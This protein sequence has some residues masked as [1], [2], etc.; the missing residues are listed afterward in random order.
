MKKYFLAFVIIALAVITWF[1]WNYIHHK[2]ANVTKAVP[3]TQKN[4][5]RTI[6]PASFDKTEYSIDKA[7]S[8]WVVVNKKRPLSA[9][10]IPAGLV[11]HPLGG[12]VRPEASN[13]LDNLLSAAKT[14]GVTFKMISA[15]RSYG[16]QASVYNGYV[17]T[18]GQANADT[19]SARPGHS[20]HQTGLAADLGAQNGSCDLEACFGDTPAGQWLAAHAHEHGFI[21]RY[22]EGKESVTGY[23]Y[24]PWHIRFVGVEL[25]TELVKTG[26]TMEE[27]FG[28]PAAPSY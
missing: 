9:D 21:I 8:I 5:D 2:S 27:F 6:P 20:E 13:A 11:S 4:P 23:Q 25:A 18:D 1:G 3:E 7:D 22:H 19:Y 28:L 12:Q 15:Y 26:Q 24:E 17:Q 14:D 10:Y 16:S